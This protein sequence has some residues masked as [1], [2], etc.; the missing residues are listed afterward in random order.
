MKPIFDIRSQ[1]DLL[2]RALEA[3]RA[4]A[5]L[6]FRDLAKLKPITEDQVGNEQAFEQPDGTLLLKCDLAGSVLQMTVGAGEWK[7]RSELN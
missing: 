5:R 2:P 7:W 1:V 4:L 3:W 6:V